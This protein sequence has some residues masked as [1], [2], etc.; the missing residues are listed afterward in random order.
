MRAM[1]PSIIAGDRAVS[2]FERRFEPLATTALKESMEKIEYTSVV[3]AGGFV[4]LR[5]T[6]G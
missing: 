4:Y 5:K 6:R 1:I 2:R 3:E